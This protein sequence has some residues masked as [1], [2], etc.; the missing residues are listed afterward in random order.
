M[1][2]KTKKFRS[3]W[4][5]V[6]VEGATSDGRKIERNWL[7]QIASTYDPNKYGARIFIEHI[8]GLNPEWGF[9][10]MGDVMAVKT[11]TVQIDGKDHLALMAQIQPP[12]N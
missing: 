2:T 5:R 4:F 9:R 7:E 6:A 1:S 10:C 12:T 3:N 8:R 11:E